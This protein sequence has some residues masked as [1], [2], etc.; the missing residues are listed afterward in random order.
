MYAPWPGRRKVYS[1]G[2][3]S[4]FMPLIRALSSPPTLAWTA[5]LPQGR[6]RAPQR[7]GVRIHEKNA[8]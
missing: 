5:D 7:G 6:G 8:F 4:G 3:Q 2:F 1:D